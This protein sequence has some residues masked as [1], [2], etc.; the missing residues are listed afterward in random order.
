MGS[1][2]GRDEERLSTLDLIRQVVR[3][4]IQTV[5]DGAELVSTSIR[6]ELTSFRDETERRLL[7]FVLLCVGA[8]F[9]TAGLVGFL[10]QLL[11]NWPLT[12]VVFGAAYLVGGLLLH[13][14]RRPSPPAASS[15]GLAEKD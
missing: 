4:L 5:E 8:G 12:L 11:D 1:D 7:G 13:I 2:S 10:N 9:T 15:G 14:G 6:E 3:S